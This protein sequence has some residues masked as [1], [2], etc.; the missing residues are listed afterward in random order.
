MITVAGIAE[1]LK[2]EGSGKIIN[3]EINDSVKQSFLRQLSGNVT[4]DSVVTLYT[5]IFNANGGSDVFP[6]EMREGGKITIPVKPVKS[7]YEFKGWYKDS[8]F[9]SQWDFNND[10][11][12]GAVSLFVK[13]KSLNGQTESGTPSYIY[14]LPVITDNRSEENKTDEV[15]DAVVKGTEPEKSMMSKLLRILKQAT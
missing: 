10:V 7:G 4:V 12:N 2:L 8:A 9:A 6:V 3:A 11:V 15:N 14:P 1:N 5:V 13:W